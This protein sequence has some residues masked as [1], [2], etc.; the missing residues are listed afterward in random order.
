MAL[1]ESCKDDPTLDS[2]LHIIA[3]KMLTLITTSIK[4]EYK[5]VLDR[6][7]SILSPECPLEKC[8]ATF[9]L[10]KEMYVGNTSMFDVKTEAIAKRVSGWFS[11]TPVKPGDML[12]RV[13]ELQA[14]LRLVE[15]LRVP[16]T[17]DRLRSAVMEL[18]GVTLRE[19]PNHPSV[20]I[21][22]NEYQNKLF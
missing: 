2:Q 9:V 10:L 17:D 16:M 21:A 1:I 19:H 6:V 3:T 7:D 20:S 11:R 15:L 5:P 13:N 12:T 8:I 14:M 4:D 18:F 22:W